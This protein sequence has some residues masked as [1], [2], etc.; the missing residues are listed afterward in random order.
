M[1]TRVAKSRGVS[2]R[3]PRARLI[4]TPS[5]DSPPA[6]SPMIAPTTASVAPTRMPPKIEGRAPGIS[7]RVSTWNGVARKTL[8]TSS[9]CRSTERTP[10]MVGVRSVDRQLLEVGRVFRATPFQVLTRL[11][12]PGALPSIFGGMRVGA[13]LAVVGAII[14][15]WAGGESGLGVLINLA[16]GSL[17][18]TPLLFATLVTIAALG[19]ALYGLIGLVERRLLGER[20]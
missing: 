7:S 5:P 9:S 18:D 12:I 4:S 17:F 15:E 3:L 19:V 6:H 1:V 2:N 8:P 20:G 14:G 13:T 11:E 16:R 10:T